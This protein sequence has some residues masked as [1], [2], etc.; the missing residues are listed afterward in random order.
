MGWVSAGAA[1]GLDGDEPLALE[2][3]AAAGVA[4]DVVDWDD[5]WVEWGLYDRL[6]LRSTWDYAER[7]E[8]FLGW[9]DAVD[10]V[11]DLRNPR[12]MVV[13]S[14]DKHYLLDLEQSG[15]PV[16][17]TT[18]VK[19]GEALAFPTGSVVVKPAVGAGGRDTAVYASEE[20]DLAR[21]HV[22]EL[23]TAGRTA[24]LQ[25]ALASVAAEGEWAL[26]Y[27]GGVYSHAVN[28]RVR[29]PRAGRVDGL[30][31][32]QENAPHTADAQQLTVAEAAMEYA[33][34]RF[35]VPTYARVDL[36]RGEDGQPRVLELELVEPT[37]FLKY[38]DREAAARLARV[39]TQ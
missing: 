38:A 6:V 33:T 23:H 37:L 4:V 28:K 15:V 8:A 25:P 10:A 13:W 24:L 31:A 7:I 20:H 26:I 29:L 19:P 5:A 17:P 16:V 1:R 27:L 2:A 30:F 39:I 35:G 11:T 9:L 12:S 18:A 22:G 34:G 36:V 32:A 14:L 21:A 3:L